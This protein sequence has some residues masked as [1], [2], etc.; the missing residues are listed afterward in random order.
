VRSLVPNPR[1]PPEGADSEVYEKNGVQVSAQWTHTS[2]R[3]RSLVLEWA[4]ARSAAAA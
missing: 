3:L 2:R 4:P 1:I